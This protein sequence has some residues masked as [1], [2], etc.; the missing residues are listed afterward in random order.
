MPRQNKPIIRPRQPDRHR[1]RHILH[2][3]QDPASRMF[4][5]NPPIQSVERQCERT[6][7]PRPPVPEV[8]P[9]RHHQQQHPR[10]EVD[11]RRQYDPPPAHNNQRRRLRRVSHGGLRVRILPQRLRHTPRHIVHKVAQAERSR[12]IRLHERLQNRR[13]LLRASRFLRRDW[14]RGIRWRRRR[15][16]AHVK[17]EERPE[18]L[19]Q[20][21]DG[22]RA[23]RKHPLQRRLAAGGE[24]LVRWFLELLG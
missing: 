10:Q 23:D 8:R 21:A 4:V 9:Y 19:A 24:V 15:R 14:T 5:P 1:L 17:G 22:L 2:I 16:N 13:A 3:V 20:A 6:A 7:L 11:A 12:A 18:I